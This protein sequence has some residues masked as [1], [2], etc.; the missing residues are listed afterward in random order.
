MIEAGLELSLNGPTQVLKVGRITQKIVDLAHAGIRKALR[1]G[2]P[3][4]VG[5]M[6]YKELTVTLALLQG[7][8]VEEETVS[9]A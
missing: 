3:K 2:I 9:A 8:I 5:G 7:Y 4:M 6:N 1:S